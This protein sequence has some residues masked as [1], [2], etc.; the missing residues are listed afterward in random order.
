MKAR[1]EEPADIQNESGRGIEDL[2]DGLCSLLEL[3]PWEFHQRPKARGPALARRI[4]VWLW[5][6][7]CHGKQVDVARA[8][9]VPSSLVSRWYKAAIAE[10]PDIEELA[11]RVIAALPEPKRATFTA[12]NVGGFMSR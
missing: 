1:L 5:V 9:K 2:I 12:V 7:W 10:A 6:R 8:L 4:L 3:E 11:D